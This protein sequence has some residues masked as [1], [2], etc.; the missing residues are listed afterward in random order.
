MILANNLVDLAPI[1]IG[2]SIVRIHADNPGKVKDG[3]LIV[4]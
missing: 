1:S 2:L 3:F 4:S